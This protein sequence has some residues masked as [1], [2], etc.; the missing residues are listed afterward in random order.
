MS[1][2]D[3]TR[4][5]RCYATAISS[6]AA[7]S[8]GYPF[9]EDSRRGTKCTCLDSIWVT[10]PLED[11]FVDLPS[12]KKPS[13]W[14]LPKTERIWNPFAFSAFLRNFFMPGS[15][16]SSQ[17]STH[18]RRRKPK[19]PTKSSSPASALT[20]PARATKSVSILHIFVEVPIILYYQIIHLSHLSKNLYHLQAFQTSTFNPRNQNTTNLSDMILN[21]NESADVDLF[22]LNLM[23]GKH[24]PSTILH[25]FLSEPTDSEL[26]IDETMSNA[27][28]EYAFRNQLNSASSNPGPV[29]SPTSPH[30]SFV[31]GFFSLSF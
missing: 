13:L 12:I 18:P 10:W 30:S 3:W 22:Q 20:R 6:N 7:L 21:R 19:A 25:L 31:K 2:S 27:P 16:T 8:T 15:N 17:N 14:Y 9:R 29:L 11:Q 24:H 23:L 5:G 4:S 28:S 26:Q 1:R